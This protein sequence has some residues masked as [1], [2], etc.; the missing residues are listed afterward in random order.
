MLLLSGCADTIGPEFVGTFNLV[1]RNGNALSVPMDIEVNGSRCAHRI[2][3]STLRID[4]NGRWSENSRT[5]V[6]CEEP[7]AFPAEPF[8]AEDQGR[9]EPTS[10]S[11]HEI[12]L[13]SRELDKAGMT[14]KVTA[15]GSRFS[16]TVRDRNDK[17][18]AFVYQRIP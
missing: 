18:T 9:A 5:Q 13:T 11:A 14:Q 8:D 17:V 7:G 10:D 4:G 12:I 16:L 3:Y 1:E 6:L 2:L 15:T